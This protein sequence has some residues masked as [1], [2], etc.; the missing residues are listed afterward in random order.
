MQ[1]GRQRH[2]RI[3]S[4][5]PA[6]DL[7]E[8]KASNIPFDASPLLLGLIVLLVAMC[9]SLGWFIIRDTVGVKLAISD[10]DIAL[11]WVPTE[12]TALDEL[13]YRELTKANG[14][15]PNGDLR[16]AQGLAERAL[17]AN[18]LDARALAVLGLVAERQRDDLRA[19]ELMEMSGGR[20]W[21]DNVTQA[22]L[23]I[24]YVK[25][26]EF[27]QALLRLDAILRTNPGFL[28]N[29][30]PV[31]A[32]LTKED[33][34][35]KALADFLNVDPPT[36]R[37][38]FLEYWA[39]QSSDPQRVEQFYSILQKGPNPPLATEQRP[40]LDRLIK[41]G[42]V[43]DAYGIWRANLRDAQREP[44]YVYN[45]DFAAPIDGLPFNWLL[46][47]PPGAQIDVVSLSEVE[48]GRALHILFSGGRVALDDLGQILMLPPGE[49]RL[50]G[51]V[52]AAALR[53][54]R[55]LSWQIYCLSAPTKLLGQSKLVNAPM[56][57]TPFTVE[58]SVPDSDCGGQWLKLKIASRVESE[59][60]IQG[61]VWYAGIAVEKP[62]SGTP[63]AR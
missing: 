59:K 56:A 43:A 8:E 39:V 16:I 52:K 6:A 53:T 11:S 3:S 48:N 19:S 12:S 49:Y 44:S 38:P 4:R 41:D 21:R 36:W 50:K 13:A 33:G 18:P 24:H 55:G 54:P 51:N 40:Y 57:W 37:S 29:A 22:W 5:A 17:R 26:Q 62:T 1:I 61:E 46:R 35:F 58:F 60:Q 20:T 32:A 30:L 2:R 25:T 7:M 42:R 45:G 47:S 9:V 34:S 31:L 15:Q 28:S 63:R 27:N 14:D 10:P 23:F